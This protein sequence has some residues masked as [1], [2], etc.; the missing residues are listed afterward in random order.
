MVIIIQNQGATGI[1]TM[2]ELAFLQTSASVLQDGWDIVAHKVRRVK[3]FDLCV[4]LMYIDVNE[5]YGDHKC[6]Y[7]CQNSQ[8]SYTCLCPSGY[9]L[10]HDGRTCEGQY[11][12][13]QLY[14]YK[15]Y[16][17]MHIWSL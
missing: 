2:E 11:S 14:Y 12:Y 3:T 7:E 15:T 13:M 8:G 4:T 10:K 6:E 1:V 16:P 9:Q 5:C 17:F